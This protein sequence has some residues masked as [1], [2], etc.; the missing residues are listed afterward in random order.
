[1]LGEKLVD[2]VYLPGQKNPIE[3]REN[4]A[5]LGI[6]ALARDEA[7]RAS[8][9]LRMKV[10][11][12][13]RIK[14]KLDEVPG[15]G[16]KTRARLLKACGSVRAIEEEDAAALRAAGATHQQAAAILRTFHGPLLPSEA[17]RAP[18]TPVVERA[19]EVA[20][21]PS[22]D[23]GTAEEQSAEDDAIANAFSVGERSD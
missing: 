7:H 13:R 10:G 2:R 3:L 12:R 23:A 14:S 18:A 5:A 15:I 6:L 1:M 22:D 16:T 19:D 9:A 4:H 17:Q 20:V 11:K 8:N 21:E